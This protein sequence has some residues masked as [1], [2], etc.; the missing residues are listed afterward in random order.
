M[1]VIDQKLL[2]FNGVIPA[3]LKPESRSFIKNGFPPEFIPILFEAGMTTK[4]LCL[5]MTKY[6]Y[7]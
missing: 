5:A 4:K 1:I 2:Q 3:V 7:Q 6:Y